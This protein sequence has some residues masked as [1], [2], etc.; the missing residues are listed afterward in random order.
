MLLW[1]KKKE[2]IKN[3]TFLKYALFINQG[4]FRFVHK[5]FFISDT[6]DPMFKSR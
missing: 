4:L 1:V 6:V 3:E 5:L 2:K